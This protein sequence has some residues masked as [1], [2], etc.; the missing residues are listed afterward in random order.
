MLLIGYYG[1]AFGQTKPEKSILDAGTFA[2]L[3]KRYGANDALSIGFVDLMGIE[4]VLAGEA[5]NLV[6]ESLKKLGAPLPLLQGDCATEFGAMAA[7]MPRV[8]FAS[9]FMGKKMDVDLVFEIK[10]AGLMADLKKVQASIPSMGSMPAAGTFGVF[11]IAFDLAS[12]IE[13]LKARMNAMAAAPYKCEYLAELNDAIAEG[14][15]EIEANLDPAGLPPFVMGL[16]GAYVVVEDFTM[17]QG[18]M[19]TDVKA[20]ALVGVDN[21]AGTWQQLAGMV[22]FFAGVELGAGATA[23][24]A[25]PQ[26]PMVKAPHAMANDKVLALSVG[27]GMNA[28]LEGFASGK[29]E[30]TPLMVFGYDYARFMEV[31]G[32][33]MDAEAKEMM[34]YMSGVTESLGFL[35]MQVGINDYGVHMSYGMEMK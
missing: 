30:G 27:E 28:K 1:Y 19:P 26:A 8:Y 9:T 20:L 22:P 13:V 12:G 11:G 24:P 3:E 17:G 14:S 21:P 18:G 31:V 7:G 34:D 16:K 4:K 15:K 33:T 32:P 2:E 23:L 10:D 29:A 5:Q 6:T 25:I 35:L